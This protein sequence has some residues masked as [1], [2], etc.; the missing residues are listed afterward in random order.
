MQKVQVENSY[1]HR[2]LWKNH[3]NQL[4]EKGGLGDAAF[5]EAAEFNFL[6]LVGL[7]MPC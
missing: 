3:D 5:S 4:P 2:S 1:E 7:V 6:P